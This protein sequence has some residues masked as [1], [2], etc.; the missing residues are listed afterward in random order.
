ML[1]KYASR[2]VLALDPDQAGIS[3]T[4]RGLNVARQTLEEENTVSFDPRGM[5]RY[6]GT[7]DMDLRVVRLPEGLDPDDFIRNDPDA[8]E[9]LITSAVP[10]ADY[11]VRQGTAHLT[12]Q[13]SY[14]EREAV[15]REL[16]PILTATESDLQRN[17]N[18]QAL[19]RR[20]KIDERTLIQWTQRRQSASTRTVPTIKDQRKMADVR[21]QIVSVGALPGQSLHGEPFCLQMLL[22]QPERLY[23]ANR[24]LRELQG[25]DEQLSKVL[26]SLSAEDFS[27]TD[28]QT[29]FRVLEQSLYQDEVDTL[30]YLQAQLA[31]ELAAAVVELQIDQLDIFQQR[32]G[33]MWATELQSILREQMRRN[34]RPETTTGLFIQEV[35]TL[36]Y[37]R[38]ERESHELYFLQQDARTAGDQPTEHYYEAAIQTTL[39]AQGLI[40]VA[41][42]QLKSFAHQ[43]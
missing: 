13:S 35:L 12:N 43:P 10:V 33:K 37:N 24:K 3:A 40:A 26:G 22:Q 38:L 6:T 1:D 11:V 8:W 4:M 14:Q 31:P 28:Y 34:A 42:Q 5:M 32:S 16:L 21:P 19:A 30:E 25:R 41:L 18:I 7:L 20:V 29:I 15:A 36:R 17:G 9:A 39:R 2:L 27:R 23:A